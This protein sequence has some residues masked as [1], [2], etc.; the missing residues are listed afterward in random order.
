MY[1]VRQSPHYHSD[2]KCLKTKNDPKYTNLCAAL[3][4]LVRGRNQILEEKKTSDSSSETKSSRG[5]VAFVVSLACPS[6]K[7]NA[8]VDPTREPHFSPL[9]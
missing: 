7:I 3:T 4:N 1:L 2:G 9:L 6:S 5:E 8:G